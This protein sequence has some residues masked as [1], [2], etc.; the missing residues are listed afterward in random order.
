MNRHSAGWIL[1]MDKSK[2]MDCTWITN[3]NTILSF[4]YKFS[5]LVVIYQQFHIFKSVI[6]V[7]TYNKTFKLYNRH[8]NQIN[9]LSLNL[10]RHYIFEPYQ[11]RIEFSIYFQPEW[12]ILW[13]SSI[14]FKYCSSSKF[15]RL[16]EPSV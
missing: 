3:W 5:L 10:S 11:L 16:R 12:T 14:D 15:G 13:I 8:K 4:L 9:I 6:W 7:V 1:R 2:C